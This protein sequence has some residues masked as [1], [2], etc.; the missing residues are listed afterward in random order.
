M[1]GSQKLQNHRKPLLIIITNTYGFLLCESERHGQH[2]LLQPSQE[3]WNIAVL[4]LS[5][6]MRKLRFEEFKLPRTQLACGKVRSGIQVCEF[7]GFPLMM[8]SSSFSSQCWV[9][10]L[11]LRGSVDNY[12]KNT[13]QLY[14]P[15]LLLWLGSFAELQWLKV[16]HSPTFELMEPPVIQL[17]TWNFFRVFQT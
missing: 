8:K 1:R 6:F 13:D 12:A 16:H 17:S 4:L 14:A 9:N 15:V 7:K 10:Q 3:A 2:Y 5:L 11:F